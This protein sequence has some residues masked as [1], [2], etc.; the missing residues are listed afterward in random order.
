VVVT[1]DGLGEYRAELE[2]LPHVT[3]SSRETSELLAGAAVAVVPAC[4]EEPFGRVAFEALS[5]GVPVV[6]SAV[7]G[8]AEYV[9]VEGLLARDAPVEAWVEAVSRLTVRRAWSAAASRGVAAAQ[10]LLAARGV[11][12]VEDLLARVASHT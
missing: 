6:A 3:L 9:P 8:L 12:Q 7:G 5:L 11:N 10:G 2:R 4:W 1:E